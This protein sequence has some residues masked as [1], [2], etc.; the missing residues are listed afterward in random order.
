MQVRDSE[1]RIPSCIS[2][3]LRNFL[4]YTRAANDSGPEKVDNSQTPYPSV[5][6]RASQLLS[7]Y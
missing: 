4:N 7:A 6:S 5:H 2:G 1:R 3:R